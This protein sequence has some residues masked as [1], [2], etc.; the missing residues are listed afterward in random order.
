MGNKNREYKGPMPDEILVIRDYPAST[1]SLAPSLKESFPN[2]VMR[3][4]DTADLHA[5]VLDNPNVAM[6]V[7]PGIVGEKS[8]YPLT[9]GEDG[10]KRIH[11][12]ASSRGVVL[13][14][15]AATYF[16]CRETSYKPPWGTPKGRNTINYLFNAAARGPVPPYARMAVDDPK[17]GDVTVIPVRF[18]NAKG[19]W[20][21]GHVCYGNGPALHPHAS[22]SRTS[23]ILATFSGTAGNAPALIRKT[24]GGGALYLSC[25]HP[26]IGYHPV[27]EKSGLDD[28]RRVMNALKPHEGER[29]ELWRSLVERIKGDLRPAA[30]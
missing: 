16:V 21:D 28:A 11:K 19:E 3:L 17:F 25:I 6:L 7:L 26:E 27:S 9:I 12:F 4:I 8:P 18:K 5:G 1:G 23:E 13:T 15:C 2:H 30:S 10:L 29:R 14:I 22:E 20:R 24:I